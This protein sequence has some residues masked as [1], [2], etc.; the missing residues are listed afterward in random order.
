MACFAL[1]LAGVHTDKRWTMYELLSK[2]DHQYNTILQI[3]LLN[4]NASND[5][6]LNPVSCIVSS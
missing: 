3:V 6:C 1:N 4:L 5:Y 2:G